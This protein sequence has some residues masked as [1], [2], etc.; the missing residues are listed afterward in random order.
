MAT[1]NR[2]VTVTDPESSLDDG[3][4]VCEG[5]TYLPVETDDIPNKTYNPVFMEED[6][7]LD[8]LIF[9]YSDMEKTYSFRKYVQRMRFLS[10]SWRG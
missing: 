6:G 7:N 5:D 1:T 3:N 10:L 8:N 4:D 2:I 9:K